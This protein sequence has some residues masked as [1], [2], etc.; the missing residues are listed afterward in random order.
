MMRRANVAMLLAFGSLWAGS[1]VVT[2]LTMTTALPAAEPSLRTPAF[3]GGVT[4]IA[5]GQ[6]VFLVVVGT[7]LFPGASRVAVAAMETLFGALFVGGFLV[8]AAWLA[9]RT[10]GG[11]T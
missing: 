6:Y 11:G 5:A 1:L 4:A 8:A 7:R 10:I 9:A 2:G 3:V